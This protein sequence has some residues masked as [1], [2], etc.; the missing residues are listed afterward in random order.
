MFKKKY[1]AAHARAV[2]VESDIRYFF[3]I[4]CISWVFYAK[5]GVIGSVGAI[6]KFI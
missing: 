1:K 2:S 4:F 6:K 3:V 5:M